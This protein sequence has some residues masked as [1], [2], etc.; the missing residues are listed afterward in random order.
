MV[1]L[2][3][4]VATVLFI[5]GIKRM[6]NVRTARRGNLMS[7]VGMLLAIVAVLLEIGAFHW[8]VL[9]LGLLVGSA[10][11]ADASTCGAGYPL[12]TGA[13]G[14]GVALNGIGSSAGAPVSAATA[15]QATSRVTV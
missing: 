5:I 13:V 15:I 11:G 14:T 8:W 4:V 1:G 7:S 2:L 10:I 9:V 12:S 6:A 3:Y